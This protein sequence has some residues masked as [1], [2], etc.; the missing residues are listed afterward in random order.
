MRSHANPFILLFLFLS[1]VPISESLIG[2]DCSSPQSNITAISLVSTQGCS[3]KEGVVSTHTIHGQVL[4]TRRYRHVHVKTCL[5]S[6]IITTQYCGALNH[7]F[8]TNKPVV[9]NIVYLGKTACEELHNTGDVVIMG[10]HIRGVKSNSTSRTST[11]LSGH[12]S[13]SGTCRNG[14][15]FF[16]PDG[17]STN[18]KVVGASIDITIRD[19]SATLEIES[20]Y[21]VLESMK[22]ACQFDS[23]YCRD[24]ILGEA[25]WNTQSPLCFEEVD[26]LYQGEIEIGTYH[27]SITQ[28]SIATIDSGEHIFAL[29][30]QKF[31]LLCGAQ[32][33]DTEHQRIKISKKEGM[34]GL[35]PFSEKSI[36][37]RNVD[38]R[39][40]IDSKFLFV[41]SSI[42]KQTGRM[43]QGLM[44]DMCKLR[45]E[46]LE[47]RLV[48][49]Q[50]RS[51]Q[52]GALIEKKG[53]VTASV[54]GEVLYVTVCE[55]VPVVFRKGE[56][57]TLE[58]PITY[59]GKDA[60][61]E[62][63]TH[64]IK[65]AGTKTI[66]SKHMS[67]AYK[68]DG[69]WMSF[70]N[71][72]SSPTLTPTELNPNVDSQEWS[73]LRLLDIS[74]GGLYDDEDMDQL[75]KVMMF[76]SSRKSLSENLAKTVFDNGKSG[77]GGF[78]DI[79][80]SDSVDSIGEMIGGM[81]WK[82][83]KTMGDIG[84]LVVFVFIMVKLTFSVIDMCINGGSIYRTQ[85]GCSLWLL[86]VPFNALVHLLLSDFPKRKKTKRISIQDSPELGLRR[87]NDSNS[88]E[89]PLISDQDSSHET[90]ASAPYDTPINQLESIKAGQDSSSSSS[91]SNHSGLTPYQ[92]EQEAFEREK[93]NQVKRANER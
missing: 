4:Q 49:S 57:C 10:H 45:K 47:N 79:A 85:G 70:D 18:G 34:T 31:S 68:I 19:F 14:G 87:L 16:Y 15:T 80:T 92:K 2:Y 35:Y 84:G 86:A 58:F 72:L 36:L 5:I 6:T 24:S 42:L 56:Q 29:K 53:G 74:K 81:T 9:S 12:G 39:A 30:I 66:C 22:L 51:D 37:S 77:S 55:P 82:A 8:A 1:L 83:M 11:Y 76:G 46:I 7:L 63:I 78:M 27:D 38:L 60:F 43:Y 23:G 59:Q 54:S 44:L 40:Y 21:M 50:I 13:D 91:F 64:I 3:E 41:T 71:Q 89:N 88:L 90:T 33:M 20:N 52:V 62:P 61:L 25:S 26:V 28:T 69:E 48:L 32:V 65:Y 73:F 93:Y 17:S 67:P 75:Q